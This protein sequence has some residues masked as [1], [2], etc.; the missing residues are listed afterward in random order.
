MPLTSRIRGPWF[1][2]DRDET[3]DLN[4]WSQSATLGLGQPA[5]A[6]ARCTHCGG[7]VF[8]TA[9]GW[10]LVSFVAARFAGGG[11]TDIQSVQRFRCITD[12]GDAMAEHDA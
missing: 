6:V 9:D 8:A 11:G 12:I 2:P 1:V 3:Q 5:H 10:A 7:T 4:R